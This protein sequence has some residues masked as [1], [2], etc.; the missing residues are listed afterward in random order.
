M[1]F[2]ERAGWKLVGAQVEC[3]TARRNNRDGTQIHCAEQ[4]DFK[5]DATNHTVLFVKAAST[6]AK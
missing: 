1:P 4:E 5:T 6:C 2:A 3:D